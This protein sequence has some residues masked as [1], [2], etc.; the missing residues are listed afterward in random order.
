MINTNYE[1]DCTFYVQSGYPIVKFSDIN[2]FSMLQYKIISAREIQGLMPCESLVVDGDLNVAYMP[3][4]REALADSINNMST[5]HAYRL[6]CMM[7]TVMQSVVSNGYLRLQ[8]IL[9]DPAA[10]YVNDDMS[11]LLL[12]YIPSDKDKKK[13]DVQ[14]QQDILEF[15]NRIMEMTPSTNF[16]EWRTCLEHLWGKNMRFL[17]FGGFI[18]A[19]LGMG[20]KSGR[21]QGKK[22]RPREMILRSTNLNPPLTIPVKQGVTR[23]GRLKEF[24]DIPLEQ[25]GVI[26]SRHCEISLKKDVMSVKDLKSKNGT[27]IN[28]KRLEPGREYPLKAGD[29][30]GIAFYVFDVNAV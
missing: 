5:G 22:E 27:Y 19:A 3:G 29:Q 7:V 30:I 9:L 8:N 23:I 26:S 17:E 6:I 10:I 14:A 11:E 16:P 1:A 28:G 21:N 15:F 24:S 18:I 12:T 20:Y 2:T 4:D 13:G 25:F